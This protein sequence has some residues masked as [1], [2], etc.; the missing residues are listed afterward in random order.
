MCPE[1]QGLTE[2]QYQANLVAGHASPSDAASLEAR[3]AELE[4]LLINTAPASAL[5][6]APSAAGL[7]D[8]MKVL[9]WLLDNSQ[10]LPA[11][12]QLVVEYKAAQGLQDKWDV[13]KLIGDK[14]VDVVA[15][16]PFDQNSGLAFTASSVCIPA[17]EE[18]EAAEVAALAEAQAV[19]FD[20]L[21]E[22]AQFLIPL[23]VEILLKLRG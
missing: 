1:D 19:D 10:K 8:R 3:I 20:K 11:L 2:A 21:K 16:F 23:V 7:V 17:D 13:V 12:L 18:A 6:V 5:V 22:L 9:R 15:S 14:I 4:A